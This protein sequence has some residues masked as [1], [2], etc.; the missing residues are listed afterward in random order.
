MNALVPERAMVPSA[1]T[2]SSRDMPMP[3]SSTAS[4]RLSASTASVMRGFASSPS[5]FGSAI[6]S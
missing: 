5:S 4:V 1:S 2:I 3:L 6:A